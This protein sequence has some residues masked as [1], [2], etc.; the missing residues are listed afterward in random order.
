MGGALLADLRGLAALLRGLARTLHL[1]LVLRTV[2]QIA[3]GLGL[4]GALCAGGLGLRVA[5]QGLGPGLRLFQLAVSR[6][7]FLRWRG[8][9]GVSEGRVKVWE[10]GWK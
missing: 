2:L 9:G 5:L 7:L 1:G 3:R 10:G 6:R 4:R 8:E